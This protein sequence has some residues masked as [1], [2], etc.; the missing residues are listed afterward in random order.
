MRAPERLMGQRVVADPAAIDALVASLPARVTVLRFAPDEA[1]VV[2]A[3]STRVDDPH[4]IIEDEVG[5]VA[6][7]VDREVVTRH[8]EWALPPAGE[9]VQ[10]SIAG[11]PAKLA[12]LPNGQ[13]WIVTHAA[14]AAEL[15]DRLT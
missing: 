13:A 7:A 8:V 3:G 4:A 11:V 5:F 12:W 14:Y 1:F 10:G 6:L 15:V 9:V 2:G